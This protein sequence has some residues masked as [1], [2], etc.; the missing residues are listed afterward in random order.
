[1]SYQKMV[2]KIRTANEEEKNSHELGDR[3]DVT[4]INPNIWK[5][6]YI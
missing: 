4:G 5:V 2:V 3:S 6:I 1:M